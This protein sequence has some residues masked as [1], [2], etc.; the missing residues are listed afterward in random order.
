MLKKMFGKL[1]ASSMNKYMIFFKTDENF[2]K[3]NIKRYIYKACFQLK[4]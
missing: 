2:N 3:M 4:S 1:Q